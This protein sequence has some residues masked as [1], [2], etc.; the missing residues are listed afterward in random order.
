[1]LRNGGVDGHDPLTGYRSE[2][3][4]HS[5]PASFPCRAASSGGTG[6]KSERCNLTCNVERRRSHQTPAP[7]GNPSAFALPHLSPYREHTSLKSLRH[8]PRPVENSASDNDLRGISKSQAQI[9][10]IRNSQNHLRGLRNFSRAALFLFSLLLTFVLYK[11][12]ARCETV[13]PMLLDSSPDVFGRSTRKPRFACVCW[14]KSV[15]W[16]LI[17][18]DGG[19]LPGVI[20]CV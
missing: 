2:R 15:E 8:S 6:E 4:S 5:A 12:V 1:M 18:P 10:R 9:D 11:L 17:C 7:R 13:V 14:M 3:E 16:R 20:L 19:R